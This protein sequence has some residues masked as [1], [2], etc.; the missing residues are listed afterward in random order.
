MAEDPKVEEG[1]AKKSSPI[2]K[3]LILLGIAILVPVIIGLLAYKFFVAPKLGMEVMVEA[4]VDDFPPFPATMVAVDFDKMNV[5]VQTEDPDLIAPLLIMQ[6]SLSCADDMTAAK[7]MEK[8]QYFAAEILK[9]HQG[10]TRK[11]LNDPLVKNSILEQIRQR[12]NILLKR[13]SPDMDLKVLEAMYVE[14][15]VMDIG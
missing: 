8:K 10:R 1:G 15:T 13:L 4:P 14:F 11:E 12:S 7:I 9:L 5:S 2:L 6:V 3:H